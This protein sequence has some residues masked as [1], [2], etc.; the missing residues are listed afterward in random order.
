LHAFKRLETPLPEHG[1]K[2]ADFFISRAGADKRM[3]IR[4]A[5]FIREAGLEPFYQS[6]D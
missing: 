2:P 4:I 5:A 3:A 1:D 6:H